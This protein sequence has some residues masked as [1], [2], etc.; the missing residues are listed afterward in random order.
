MAVSEITYKG[1]VKMKLLSIIIPVYNAEEYIGKC[2]HSIIDNNDTSEIEII[3]VDDGSQ[4]RSGMICDDFSS[5]YP[6]IHVI[7]KENGGVS[8]AR[9][10]GLSVAQGDY[11]AWIDS[12]DYVEE[13][14]ETNGRRVLNNEKIE[15]RE[16]ISLKKNVFGQYK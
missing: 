16:M 13:L 15:F 9:N 5:R 10:T 6:N 4:D 12:D 11:I 2:I 3:C 14:L 8:S 1:K 7:H